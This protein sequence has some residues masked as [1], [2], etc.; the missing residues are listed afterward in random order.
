M[1][2]NATQSLGLA[3]RDVRHIP[4]LVFPKPKLVDNQWVDSVG[5]AFVEGLG[6]LKTNQQVDYYFYLVDADGNAPE[7]YEFAEI[8][9]GGATWEGIYIY[10][11]RGITVKFGESRK[12][13]VM[14]NELTQDWYRHPFSIAIKNTTTGELYELDPGQGNDG[15]PGG[16]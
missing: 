4:L 7:G 1:T 10:P 9:L 14:S 16:P 12:V 11:S 2:D 8:Q 6:E 15:K 5:I 3:G 13:V